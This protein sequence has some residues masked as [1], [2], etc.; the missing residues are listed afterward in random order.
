M[1]S[2]SRSSTFTCCANIETTTTYCICYAHQTKGQIFKVHW[3]SFAMFS[4][5]KGVARIV[6]FEYQKNQIP[7]IQRHFWSWRILMLGWF[8]PEPM[9]LFANNKTVIFAQIRLSYPVHWNRHLPQK[10]TYGRNFVHR[11][12]ICDQKHGSSP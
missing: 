4:K 5:T 10:L 1:D 8:G 7:N 3:H 11:F 2:Q 6:Y 9:Q 12:R